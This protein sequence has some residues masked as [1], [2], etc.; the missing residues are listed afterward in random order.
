MSILIVWI[1]L[2]IK[3]FRLQ[4]KIASFGPKVVASKNNS[5][6]IDS[7]GTSFAELDTS[8]ATTATTPASLNPSS[9][10]EAL[11]N[12]ASGIAA[13]LGLVAEAASV[14]ASSEF[15]EM[16]HEHENAGGGPLSG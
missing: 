14:V 4:K 6:V 1:L 5:A 3:I 16:N 7:V 11:S 8:S 9:E 2:E 10:A 12:V 13:S 15:S